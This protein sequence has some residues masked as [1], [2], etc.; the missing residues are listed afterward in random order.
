MTDSNNRFSIKL[1]SGWHDQTVYQYQGPEISGQFHTVSLSLDRQLADRNIDRFA[2]D[3]IDP[4]LESY[5][6]LD[7][8][9]REE[10]TLEGG[11]SVYE[12]AYRWIP[13]EGVQLFG[14]YVFVIK[15][16]IGFCFSCSFSKKSFKM[17]GGQMNDLI[18]SLVP[19]TYEPLKSS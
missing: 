18:E 8:L 16:D 1:P 6:G 7:V 4:I 10:V 14:K 3:R 15:D 13:S 5:Q 11:N 12:F 19:G 17:L 9:K 2:R